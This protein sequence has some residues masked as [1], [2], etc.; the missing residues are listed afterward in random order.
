M[1]LRRVRS[2]RPRQESDYPFRTGENELPQEGV[3][4]AGPRKYLG[5]GFGFSGSGISGFSVRVLGLGFSGFRVR[6]LGF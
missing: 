3:S 5:L 6:D 2:S 1:E 4:A